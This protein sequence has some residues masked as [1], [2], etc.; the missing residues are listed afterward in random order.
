VLPLTGRTRDINESGLALI[1]MAEDRRALADLGDDCTLRL[2][3]TLPAGPVELTAVP[4]R[5]V[6]LGEAGEVDFLVGARITDM[7]GRD[8]VRFMVFIRGLSDR[9]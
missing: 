7:S 1:V 2:M 9:A 4:V 8:R 6:R 3:L 5:Y